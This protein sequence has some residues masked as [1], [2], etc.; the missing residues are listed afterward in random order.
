MGGPTIMASPIVALT[1]AGYG[2]TQHCIAL[3]LCLSSSRVT[4]LICIS[5]AAHDY[6][7]SGRQH[8]Q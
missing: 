3:A 1:S 8:M 6:V 7:L 2:Q 5:F 4:S